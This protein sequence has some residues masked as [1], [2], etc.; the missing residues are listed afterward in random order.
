[1]VCCVFTE[2]C[3]HTT[4]NFRSILSSQKEALS[5][6][7]V[8]PWPLATMNLLSVS[9]DLPVLDLSYKWNQIICGLLYACH[10]LGVMFS[11][12]SVLNEA[13]VILLCGWVKFHCTDWAPFCLSINLVDILIVLVI[14]LLRIMLQQT[15]HI[16]GVEVFS[17]FLGIYPGVELLGQ[18][19]TVCLIFWGASGAAM[20]EVS[21]FPPFSAITSGSLSFWL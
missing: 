13:W 7:A 11:R 14:H 17:L 18:R 19:V 20:Y 2:L 5:P 8:T 16:F 6:S 1:M 3:S 12:C 4:V 9:V 21:N 15:L 10:S